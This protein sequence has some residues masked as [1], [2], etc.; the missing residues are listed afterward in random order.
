VFIGGRG[1]LVTRVS[2][3]VPILVVGL[4][5]LGPVLALLW[6]VLPAQSSEFVLLQLRLPRL[7]CALLVGATLGLSGAAYQAVFHNPLA[8]PSTTG[9][10][11]G[12]TLGA[13]VAF[14]FG[15]TPSGLGLPLVTL[16]ALV[17][18]LLASFVVVAVAITRRARTHDILLIGIAVTLAT[19][20][21]STALEDIAEGHVL[22]AVG[23]W[24]LGHLAQ[25]GYQR[26]AMA[27]P[28]LILVWLVLLA[29]I[30][31]LQVL[32][33]GE[34]LAH[35]RGV[36]VARVRGI[37]L[38]SAAVGVAICV[39]LAGPIAFVGLVV[40]QLVRLSL[41]TSQRRVLIGSLLGG[42]G[43]VA[44][45]DTLGRIG[46]AGREL[47]VGVV[48]AVIGAPVLGWLVFRAARER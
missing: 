1:G 18:A 47:P 9:T 35:A 10:L 33:L 21:L 16:S 25:V 22:V 41:G 20:A 13:L 48:T 34:D 17:G 44:L 43:F 5:G 15:A 4:L 11:A 23:R 24:S 38:A 8:T 42:A 12:A 27:A 3:V 2:R 36:A 30:R 40:P 37:T 6:P 7:L 26:V 39:A 29:Q 45:A 28:G 14:L 31:S 46:I 19:T 32:V